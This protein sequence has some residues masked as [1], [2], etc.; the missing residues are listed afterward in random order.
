MTA[1]DAPEAFH[2]L[3]KPTG[4][5]C[6][7]DCDYCFFLSKEQ[8]YPDSR[9][10]MSESTLEQYLRQLIEA[11]S[12]VPEV[13]IAWQGGEP[14]L[15]GL[16]FFRRSVEIARR[17]LGPG[18][19]ATHTIQTNATKLD[20]EWADFFKQNEFLVGVSIDGP[21]EIHDTYRVTRGGNGSFDQVIRGLD[22]L[23]E[24]NVDWNAL[25]TI[26]AANAGRGREVY[27]FLRDE[28]DASFMQFIPIIERVPDARS[29]GS[30]P[31]SSWRD[32]PLYVQ[33]GDASGPAATAVIEP[34]A[35]ASRAQRNRDVACRAVR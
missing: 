27:R 35:Q 34:C 32:R 5:Q 19:S 30:V 18:Q 16:D 2:L 31:W 10:R 8:L 9:F 29:D 17:Y 13:T 6:N 26:H 15:M 23:R 11:H 33:E 24:A 21:R 14:T 1:L 7:L 4:A 12:G 22:A 20:P 25:T 3:A 28:L